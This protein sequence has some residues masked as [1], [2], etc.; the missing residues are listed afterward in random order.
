MYV[1]L[2]VFVGVCCENACGGQRITLGTVTPQAL[3]TAFAVIQSLIR[4][5]STVIKL[6]AGRWSPI[7]CLIRGFIRR[8]GMYVSF[9]SGYQLNHHPSFQDTVC[10]LEAKTVLFPAD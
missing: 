6:L 2:H 5:C 3:F 7:N 9:N 1:C 8:Y 4:I 10:S